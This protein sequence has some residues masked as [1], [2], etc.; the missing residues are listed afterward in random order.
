MCSECA[1]Q[2][3]KVYLEATALKDEKI[4]ITKK[5]IRNI[6]PHSIEKYLTHRL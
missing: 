5:S 3:G 6:F 1:G 2:N 4:G